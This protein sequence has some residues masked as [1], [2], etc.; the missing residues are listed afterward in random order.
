MKTLSENAITI[1]GP[2]ITDIS[3]Y[4]GVLPKREIT[5]KRRKNMNDKLFNNYNFLGVEEEPS[6]EDQELAVEQNSDEPEAE[7]KEY[8]IR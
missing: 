8:G 1:V 4:C 2:T 5:S 7:D 6:T 3:M